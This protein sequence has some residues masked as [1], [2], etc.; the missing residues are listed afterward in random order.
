MPI[1]N[2]NGNINIGSDLTLVVITT[3]GELQ[4][5]NLTGFNAKQET[6]QI[7]VDG[8]DGI[9][10]NAKLP[11]GWSGSFALA[12]GD[13]AVDAFFAAAEAAWYNGG[14]Y[15]VGQIFV[16]IKEADGSTSTYMYTNVAFSY[17]DAGDW[18]GDKEIALKIGFEADRRQAV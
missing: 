18:R 11:K 16:Y 4:L 6:A 9:Q 1:L 15:N 14:T 13:N 17:D 7:K 3:S 2:G 8:L 10:R 12:R 5:T